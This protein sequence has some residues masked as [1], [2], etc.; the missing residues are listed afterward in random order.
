MSDNTEDSIRNEPI[1]PEPKRGTCDGSLLRNPRAKFGEKMDE[2]T[3]PQVRPPSWS[4]WPETHQACMETYFSR[5]LFGHPGEVPANG[6]YML[7]GLLR[8]ATTWH[9]LHGHRQVSQG[10]LDRCAAHEVRYLWNRNYKPG[11]VAAALS[12]CLGNLVTQRPE[13]IIERH[14]R[15]SRARKVHRSSDTRTPRESLPLGTHTDRPVSEKG[16]PHEGIG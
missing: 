8:Y 15:S 10:T 11:R 3:A 16:A 12:A 4:A 9:A 14:E 6:N 5:T 13:R 1:R 7:A 2:R